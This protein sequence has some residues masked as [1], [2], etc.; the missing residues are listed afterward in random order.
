MGIDMHGPKH[1]HIFATTFKSQF[2]PRPV[3]THTQA[4]ALSCAQLPRNVG[5]ETHLKRKDIKKLKLQKEKS[6]YE[7]DAGTVNIRPKI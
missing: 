3:S 1:R 4:H 5:T 6:I 7:A 2:I